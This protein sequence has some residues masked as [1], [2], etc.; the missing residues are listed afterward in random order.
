MWCAC[1]CV[2]FACTCATTVCVFCFC[3]RACNLLVRVCL[4]ERGVLRLCVHCLCV[5]VCVVS[6]RLCVY[7]LYVVCAFG[8][9]FLSVF[10]RVCVCICMWCV[11]GYCLCTFVCVLFA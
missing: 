8:G 11:S 4:C 6:V 1:E 5:F 2:Q 3:A 9:A 10:F 7:C